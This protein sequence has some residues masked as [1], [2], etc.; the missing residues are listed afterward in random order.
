[1]TTFRADCHSPDNFD[2][3]R[4]IQGLGGTVPHPWWYAIDT[5]IGMIDRGET[6]YTMVD[7]EVALIVVETHPTSRRRYLRTLKDS[8]LRNNLLY[9]PHCPR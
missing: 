4:R 6:F 8:V 5:I 1:M 7:G 3:D 9:L 2:T